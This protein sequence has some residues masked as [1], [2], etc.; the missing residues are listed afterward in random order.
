MEILPKWKLALGAAGLAVGATAGFV[1]TTSGVAFADPP[2]P[3]CS[4]GTGSGPNLGTHSNPLKNTVTICN[5]GTDNRT[6]DPK[7]TSVMLQWYIKGG[8]SAVKSITNIANASFVLAYSCTGKG[9]PKIASST[10]PIL[11]SDSS[12]TYTHPSNAPS[13][14]NFL[15][16][17]GICPAGD[18]VIVTDGSYFTGDVYNSVPTEIQFYWDMKTP[19]E[20]ESSDCDHSFIGGHRWV[21]GAAD[22]SALIPALGG[23][24]PFGAGLLVLAGGSVAYVATRTRRRKSVAETSN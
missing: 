5:D 18:Q 10:V 23:A 20:N 17:T 14:M 4:Q 9:T 11:T 22:P 19:T 21:V 8:A 12:Y 15:L 1:A 13:S 16:P 24:A 6:L 3:S 7:T 2:N